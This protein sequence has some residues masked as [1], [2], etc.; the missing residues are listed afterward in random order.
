MT[1]TTNMTKTHDLIGTCGYCCRTFTANKG[2]TLAQ[3]GYQVPQGWHQRTG[4][5]PAAG[6][7]A[8]ERSPETLELLIRDYADIAKSAPISAQ[9]M[10]DRVLMP[11]IEKQHKAK[12]SLGDVPEVTIGAS[13][14][15]ED[16][17][18]PFLLRN[19][20]ECY[21]FPGREAGEAAA[22]ISNILYRGYCAERD[23]P[24]LR[25]QLAEWKAG[26]LTKRAKDAPAG[27]YCEGSGKSPVPPKPTADGKPA[28]RSFYGTRY[29]RCTG[30][31]V[32]HPVTQR[33][34]I[35]KHPAPKKK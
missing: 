27:T 33:G 29:A 14:R 34:V 10:I 2:G 18:R 26:S 12:P 25:K 1:K 11:E 32:A 19:G 24:A 20:S 30:C 3:H 21:H 22:A 8:L 9:G 35:R 16:K 31:N 17:V 7:L 28:R 23:L 15:R 6:M 5:C 13:P 4:S